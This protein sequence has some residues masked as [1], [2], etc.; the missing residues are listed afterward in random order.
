L[1]HRNRLIGAATVLLGITLLFWIL[2]LSSVIGLTNF[3][4]G[5]LMGLMPAVL[6]IVMILLPMV[7]VIL[8]VISRRKD[9]QT[10]IG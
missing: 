8:A 1:I 10:Q 3:L 4:Q 5:T 7:A 9:D 2:V 6:T